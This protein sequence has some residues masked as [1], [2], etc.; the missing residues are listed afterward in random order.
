MTGQRETGQ[1]ETR[2]D[3]PTVDGL[4]LRCVSW[5]GE[6]LRRGTVVIC[7]GRTEFVEKYQGV[8]QELQERRFD[9]VLFDWRGQGLSDR[10]LPDRARGHVRRYEDYLA[11]LTAITELVAKR[12][13][14]EPRI[15]LAHS[16]GGQIGLRF[17][18]DRPEFFKGAVM[19]SPLVHMRLG[20]VT[21]PVARIISELMCLAGQ[22]D[23][24]VFGQ[25]ARPYVDHDFEGNVLTGCEKHYLELRALI[26]AD[27]ELALGGPTFGWLRAGLRS[28]AITR[29]PAF[30][31]AIRCPIL[32]AQAAEEMIVDNPAIE[33]LARLLPQGQ[34]LQLAGARHEILIER[35]PV[36]QAF[37]KGFDAWFSRL[38]G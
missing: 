3:W 21:A 22:S 11:D 25:G 1:R 4:R 23:A 6:G 32:L 29:R 19:T 17:L 14:P 33:R 18:H 2:I 9:V 38:A 26:A 36:R 30:L 27:P 12:C 15:M 13:L 35:P 16:M 31:R 5:R 24:Y 8:V 20:M 10:M 7:S 37:W 34:L 28:I